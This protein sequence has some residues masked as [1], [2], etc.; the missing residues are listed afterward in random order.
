MIDYRIYLLEPSGSFRSVHLA[1]CHD[2]SEALKTATT[3]LPDCAGV[4]IWEKKRLVGTI[5]SPVPAARQTVRS[6]AALIIAGL[7]VGGL[8]MA[9]LWRRRI[10]RTCAVLSEDT[11]L[12]GVAKRMCR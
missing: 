4:E 2:D 8:T 11:V 9:G 5:R 6:H 10:P 12:N 1:T 7:T 3:L